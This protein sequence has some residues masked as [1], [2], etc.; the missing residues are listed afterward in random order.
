MF[1]LCVNSLKENGS[2]V[3]I[4]ESLRDVHERH[5]VVCLLWDKQLRVDLF[6]AN[7][8]SYIIYAFFRLI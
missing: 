8:N 1:N 7:D 2:E 5:C 6:V 4:H 3:N